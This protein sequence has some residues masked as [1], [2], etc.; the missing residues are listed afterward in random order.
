MTETNPEVYD[1]IGPYLRHRRLQINMTQEQLADALNMSQNHISRIERGNTRPSLPLLVRWC[2]ILHVS[3]DSLFSTYPEYDDA[4]MNTL[5]RFY[6][7]DAS[8]QQWI[9]SYIEKKTE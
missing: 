6:R 2:R 5:W 3:L 9:L 4:F 7:L 1:R 8:D